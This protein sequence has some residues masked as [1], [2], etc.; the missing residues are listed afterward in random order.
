[1]PSRKNGSSRREAGPVRSS[2]TAPP[3]A[4]AAEQEGGR[5]ARRRRAA[6]ARPCRQVRRVEVAPAAGQVAGRV[7]DAP[8][9]ARAARSCRRSRRRGR[10]RRSRRSPPR[11]SAAPAGSTASTD[12]P[13][14]DA[15]DA[16]RWPPGR[17]AAAWPR[18]TAG[19]APRC[20]SRSTPSRSRRAGRRRSAPFASEPPK[21]HRNVPSSAM[22]ASATACRQARLLLELAEPPVGVERR[23]PDRRRRLAVGARGRRRRRSRR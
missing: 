12:G 3:S 5:A 16:R 20:R 9:T 23:L 11:R 14:H 22:L 1:M 21:T 15:L 2:S 4:V 8:S 6:S 13:L 10:A 18:P 17:A 7:R 19:R